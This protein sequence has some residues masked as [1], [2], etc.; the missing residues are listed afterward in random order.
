MA[1]TYTP[2]PGTVP[3]NAVR[4]LQ[5]NAPNRLVPTPELAK[6]IGADPDSVH[7]CVAKAVKH[8]WITRHWRGSGFVTH[9]ALGPAAKP[10]EVAAQKPAAKPL[11]PAGYF[12]QAMRA[13]NWP[14]R[15]QPHFALERAPGSPYLRIVDLVGGRAAG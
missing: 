7:G 5:Q 9:W 10:L 6:A 12:T 2:P 11:R 14:P 13:N 15:Y 4:W 1:R 3:Y 8:G